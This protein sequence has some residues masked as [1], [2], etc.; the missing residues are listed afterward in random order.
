[1]ELI[2]GRLQLTLPVSPEMALLEIQDD[3]RCTKLL[4]AY[5]F[6]YAKWEIILG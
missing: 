2:N 1:M 5:L 6:F 4:L 3:E